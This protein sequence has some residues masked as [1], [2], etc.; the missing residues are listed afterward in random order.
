MDSVS[1]GQIPP[2]LPLPGLTRPAA[3]NEWRRRFPRRVN[4]FGPLTPKSRPTLRYCNILRFW[5][6]V[7]CKGTPPI[8][9]PNCHPV[10]PPL[11]RR[12]E[13]RSWSA[14]RAVPILIRM[15]ISGGRRETA[16]RK[17]L[18]GRQAFLEHPFP[19]RIL[20]PH[21]GMSPHSGIGIPTGG[22]Y[23]RSASRDVGY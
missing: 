5:R 23:N 2:M 21:S 12:H 10:S 6:P 13:W 9:I 16:D 3:C 22:N 8:A 14:L 17:L 7:S 15:P 11:Q 1:P 4:R 20:L 19:Y 18:L